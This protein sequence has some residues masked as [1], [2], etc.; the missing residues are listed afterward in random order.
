MEEIKEK[1][2]EEKPEVVDVDNSD[3]P[4]LE[5]DEEE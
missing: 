4:D 3:N 1:L 5:E 2:G